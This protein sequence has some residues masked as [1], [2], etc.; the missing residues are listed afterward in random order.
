M[1]KPTRKIEPIA[2][3]KEKNREKG[4]EEIEDALVER[5]EAVLEVITLVDRL[6]E[7]ELL[8]LLSALVNHKD[9]ATSALFREINRP[10]N[11]Q[12]ARNM[13]D[14]MGFLGTIEFENMQPFL[15]RINEGMLEANKEEENDDLISMFQLIKAL[16][17]PEINR[18]IRMLLAFLKGMGKE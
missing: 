4:I 17:D 13:V 18:S 14:L 2:P 11:A 7:S 10:D 1:A 6:H 8:P 5:K 15:E 12:F 3:S 9:Q 16:K